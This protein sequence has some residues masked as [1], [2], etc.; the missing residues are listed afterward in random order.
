MRSG[1]PLPPIPANLSRGRGDAGFRRTRQTARRTPRDKA[2]TP[3]RVTS[4]TMIKTQVTLN[5][6]ESS[7][8]AVLQHH[9]AITF[10]NVGMT[11]RSMSFSINMTPSGRIDPSVRSPSTGTRTSEPSQ[12]TDQRKSEARII[13]AQQAL[14]KA[15]SI[16]DQDK[17]NHSPSCVA[18]DRKLVDMAQ[19][20]LAQAKA[21]TIG[22]ATYCPP[23]RAASSILPPDRQPPRYGAVAGLK[24][25][26]MSE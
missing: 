9:P 25:Q 14:D 19:R 12:T 18:V 11:G 20:Q 24:I 22:V 17:R 21:S 7:R 1:V 8:L 16:V 15:N 26:P 5:V 13:T 23:C 3:V 6:V 10:S 2:S 4:G